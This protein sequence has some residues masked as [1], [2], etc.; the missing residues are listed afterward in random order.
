[1]GC[2]EIRLPSRQVGL[3]DGGEIG[4]F[5]RNIGCQQRA[6]SVPGHGNNAAHEPLECAVFAF[7][8]AVLT[9]PIGSSLQRRAAARAMLCL[10]LFGRWRK[11]VATA[12]EGPILLDIPTR[13]V[14]SDDLG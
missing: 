11:D 5:L 13:L 2:F 9:R 14:R 12:L 10:C 6:A 3:T 4:A 7:D 1:M 8:A